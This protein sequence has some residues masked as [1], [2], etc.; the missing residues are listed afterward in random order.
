MGFS[1]PAFAMRNSALAA[2][3]AGPQLFSADE[4]A[5]R[6]GQLTLI[7]HSFPRRA[8]LLRATFARDLVG[9]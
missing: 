6:L 5:R 9:Y 7:G 3:E 2:L 4:V 1:G 8:K